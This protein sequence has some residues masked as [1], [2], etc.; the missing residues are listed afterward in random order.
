LR[1]ARKKTM[2]CGELIIFVFEFKLVYSAIS[3]SRKE[4][5]QAY[6][7]DKQKINTTGINDDCITTERPAAN[8]VDCPAGS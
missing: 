7:I 1:Y 3:A 2:H 5:K 6:C 4:T 8:R